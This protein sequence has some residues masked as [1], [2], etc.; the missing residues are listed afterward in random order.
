[1]KLHEQVGQHD[2]APVRLEAQRRESG[3]VVRVDREKQVAR[4]LAAHGRV[5]SAIKHQEQAGHECDGDADNARHAS[6]VAVLSL[7]V[8]NDNAGTVGELEIAEHSSHLREFQVRER[9]T[10]MVPCMTTPTPMTSAMIVPMQPAKAAPE[11]SLSVGTRH[12]GSTMS[13][14]RMV[15]VVVLKA[16]GKRPSRSEPPSTR[17]THGINRHEP[18]C[19]TTHSQR[20]VAPMLHSPRS[21]N[22]LTDL[23]ASKMTLDIVI[24]E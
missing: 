5:G 11:P 1:M 2:N 8:G 7:K 16:S 18:I 24:D 10:G 23:G 15:Q 6:R 17:N 21:P 14:M 22:V 4:D 9:H 3:V 13:A 20:P 19:E 12:T